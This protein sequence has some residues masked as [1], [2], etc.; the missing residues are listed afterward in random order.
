[1]TEFNG[2]EEATQA[3]LSSYED[4]PGEF[5]RTIMKEVPEDTEDWKDE[6]EPEGFF[7][8]YGEVNGRQMIQVLND[9]STKHAFLQRDPTKDSYEGEAFVIGDRYSSEVFQ[10]IMPDSGA[11]GISTAGKQQVQALLKLDPS[12]KVD[13]TSNQTH[14]IR[15]GK[16]VAESEGSILVRT[17]IGQVKFWIVPTNTPFLLC[18]QDM[19]SLGVRLDNLQNIIIQGKKRIPIVRKWGH[20]WMMIHTMKDT[21]MYQHFTETE[22]R[23]LHRR[24]GHPSVE[25]LYRVLQR[26]GHEETNLRTIEK[27]SKFCEQCQLH[28]KNPG[29]FRFSLRDDI[30]FN[31]SVIVDILYLSGAAVLQAVD[32]ATGFNAAR[33][34]KDN[35][36][37]TTWIT[38]RT[39]WIDTYLGPPDYFV[40]DAGTNFASAEFKANART[41]NVDVK[42]VPVEAHQSVGKVERYHAPLRRSYE[43]IWNETRGENLAKEVVLQIAVKAVNDTAG[44]NGLIPTL[45]VFGAYPRLSYEDP[46]SADMLTRARAVRKAMT[47]LRKIQA[48]RKVKDAQSMRNGPD[49]TETVRLPLQSSVKVWREK[50]GWA[51]PFSLLSVT[52]KTCIVQL[53]SGPTSFRTTVVKPFYTEEIAEVPEET[54]RSDQVSSSV[55]PVVLIPF[56]TKQELEKGLVRSLEDEVFLTRKE[57]SDLDLSRTMRAAGKITSPGFSFE[58]SQQKEI[59]GLIARGVFEF[60]RYDPRQHRGRI[61]NSR[62]VNEIKGKTTEAPY[63]KSRLVIQAYND[64]GKEQI[65]TQSPTI[66]RIS[67][68]LILAIYPSLVRKGLSIFIRDITQAYVQSTTFLNRT[69]YARL[70]KQI[71]SNYSPDTIMLVRKPLYGIPESGT[72]WW[73]T[74]DTHHKVKLHMETSSY[75]PCL[76]ITQP[77][78]PFGVVGLQTDDTLILATEEF[79]EKEERE[80]GIAG[81]SAKPKDRLSYESPLAFNGCILHDRKDFVQILQKGQGEKLAEVNLRAPDRTNQYR[82]QRARGAYIATL[83]QPEA[84]YDLSVAAQFQEPG[85]TDVKNLN[86][87]IRWQIQNVGRG[88][89]Y[90]P[91]DLH[92]TKLFVFVDGSFANNKDLSSQLGYVIIL[93]TEDDDPDSYDQNSFLLSG[94]LFH[95]SS[96]KSKRVTRSV[97]ASEIYGMVNGVDMAIAVKSTIDIITSRLEIPAIP[98]VVCT[99]SFSLYECLVKLG[100]TKEK[101][102]MIDI[103]ALRQSYERRELAEIRWINGQDN[104]ADAM[105]KSNPNKSL[106]KLIDNNQIIVRVEGWV[107]REKKVEPGEE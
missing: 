40:H 35:S 63:E 44:P 18:I 15:F 22:L 14:T 60:V 39:C 85:D 73:G 42:E 10:G 55:R 72:H 98:I 78:M 58:E 51:G 21:F 47:E 38:L 34:L 57:Q 79:Q 69:I 80:L 52:G 25:K 26:A 2:S 43:I 3:F 46:P 103:M 29:R 64:A 54:V 36:A 32:E 17:P 99:D 77:G 88:L 53:P 68:R 20:P 33:F 92:R 50:K 19:D 61:F 91:L 24:F 41:M 11:A 9:E 100:T 97:L 37:K 23:Q 94:N 12:L 74:Y 105:T 71:A 62:L 4:F 67:Q 66:Q 84:S 70:P 82:E 13:R 89:N 48:V 8:E 81:F 27:I 65:L 5:D 86:K 28:T 101:R 6:D 75:D 96:T 104:P 106:E 59:D 83:C 1:M 49:I 107:K 31:F 95:W 30:E 56:K 93:G 45:L 7:T 16:G 90:I 76:L 102:L 87:R